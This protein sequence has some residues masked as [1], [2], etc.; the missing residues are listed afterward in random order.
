MIACETHSGKRRSFKDAGRACPIDRHLDERIFTDEPKVSCEVLYVV[1]V[2][3]GNP[4]ALQAI[5]ETTAVE[6][7]KPSW[8]STG[9]SIGPTATPTIK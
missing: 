9:T 5:E 6:A 7:S 1:G 8:Y 2:L 4:F 3:Y